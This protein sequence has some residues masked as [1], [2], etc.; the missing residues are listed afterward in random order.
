MEA[1]LTRSIR[2]KI[3]EYNQNSNEGHLPSSFSIVEMLVSIF[4]AEGCPKN[5]DWLPRLILSKGHASFA[6]YAFLAATGQM[7]VEEEKEI[8]KP[9]SKLYGHLPF[10][11]SDHRFQFGSGSLG[12]GLPYAIGKSYGADTDHKHYV[13]IGDGEANEGTFWESLLLFEKFP[14]NLTVMIDSNGSSERAIKI[15]DKLEKL[16]KIFPFLRVLS[17]NGHKTGDLTNCL[18]EKGPQILICKT[19][20]GYP[21]NEMIDN[22]LWH[23][24]TPNETQLKEFLGQLK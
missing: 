23:H 17:V 5:G 13:I 14:S 16:G 12:H 15:H 2:A 20:K 11:S 22:P 4:M 9:G 8:C 21:V 24:K 3:L 7:S 19:I 18:M 1:E 10:K 6:Y